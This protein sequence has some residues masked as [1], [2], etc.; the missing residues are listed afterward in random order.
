MTWISLAPELTTFL[1]AAVFFSLSMARKSEARGNFLVAAF[2][3]GL[4]VVAALSALGAHGVFFADVYQLSFF[5]QLFKVLLALGLFLVVCLCS[6]LRGI[7]ERQHPECYLLLSLST[8][9]TM[10][11]VSSVEL[12]TLYVSLELSSYS[13]YL[14][15][16][17]RTG[18]GTHREASIKYLLTGAATS[19]VMLF[20]VALLFGATSTTNIM[21]L[22]RVTTSVMSRPLFLLGLLLTLSGL[23]FKLALF[24][25]HIWAPTVYQGAPNQVAAY[26]ATATKAAAAAVLIRIMASAGES[27]LH[28][29][30]ALVILAIASMTFGNLVAIRQKDLKRLFAYSAVAHAGYILIGILSTSEKGYA[31]AIFYAF[32]YLAMTYACFLVVVKVACDGENVTLDGLAGLHR[33][34]PLLA[35]TLLLG[36]FSLGGIPPTIG[37][38]GKF[39]VFVA[40]VEKGLFY[41]VLIGMINVVV[42]LYYYAL[43]VKAAYLTPPKETAGSIVLSPA[44]TGLTLVIGLI[45]VAGGLFPGQLYDLAIDAAKALIVPGP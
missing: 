35:M 27:N 4:G 39:L 38:T 19:A 31:G 2:I 15:V 45:I 24:P 36:V 16:A 33:R 14:L 37:F 5:S 28:L 18:E 11:M 44:M 9:G 13:L 32:A 20:G 10:M 43:I 26:I 25:F 21:E 7:E 41:L 3:S 1:M 34:S 22:Q 17:L 42:S 23:F 8:L 12:L 30:R 29:S 40:A 6:E